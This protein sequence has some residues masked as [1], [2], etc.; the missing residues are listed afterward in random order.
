MEYKNILA[1]RGLNCRR[2]F[3]H[4]EGEIRTLSLKLID[5]LGSFEK[6]AERFFVPFPVFVNYPHFK[7]LLAFFAQGDCQGCR[8]GSCKF[9]EF[10]CGVMTCYQKKGVDF[11][12]QY[13]EFPCDKS[14]FDLA[15]KQRWITRMNWMK[16]I[17]VEAFYEETKNL[18]RYR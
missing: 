3:A 17:G 14:N 5:R 8:K 10:N 4:S 12:F 15:S 1:P 11:C 13:D 6:V 9:P 2:C 18:P 7:K 16:E